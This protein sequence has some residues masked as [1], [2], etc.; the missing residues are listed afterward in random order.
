MLDE[1]NE[2]GQMFAF[3]LQ[4]SLCVSDIKAPVSQM[5]LYK[6]YYNTV[7]ADYSF[8]FEPQILILQFVLQKEKRNVP[9]DM[10]QATISIEYMKKFLAD[11]G[12]LFPE[13]KSF[14]GF[15]VETRKRDKN[16]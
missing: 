4:F 14:L 8:Y 7:R 3:S 15:L 6:V 12:R 13:K 10:L 5:C 11:L 9:H 16:S 1:K 2:N